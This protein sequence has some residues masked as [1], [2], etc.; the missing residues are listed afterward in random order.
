M[1][2]SVT[3]KGE[4]RR[5]RH[6]K[7]IIQIFKVFLTV[8]IDKIAINQETCSRDQSPEMCRYDEL[9]VHIVFRK[10]QPSITW[11]QSNHQK[12]TTKDHK[13]TKSHKIPAKLHN[14][15]NTT[16]A[17]VPSHAARSHDHRNDGRGE[18]RHST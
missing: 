2:P 11:F 8:H 12:T 14:A 16:T 15:C 13:T 3:F 1:L 18:A 7:Q 10:H 9:R 4:K 5:N 17:V 6:N